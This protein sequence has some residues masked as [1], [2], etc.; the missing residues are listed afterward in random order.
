MEDEMS[1][2]NDSGD[3][4]QEFNEQYNQEESIYDSEE[5]G[6][7]QMTESNEVVTNN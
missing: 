3:L 1:E 7:S 5:M 2:Q 6:E 4:Q